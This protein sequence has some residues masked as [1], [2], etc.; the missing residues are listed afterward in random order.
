MRPD[1]RQ[2]GLSNTN[3]KGYNSSVDYVKSML[4]ETDY[5]ISEQY[6]TITV[7]S[8]TNTPRLDQISP[9]A[10][11]YVY[12]VDYLGMTYGG[13]GSVTAG[14]FLGSILSFFPLFLIPLFVSVSHKLCKCGQLS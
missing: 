6:F 8:E 5:V 11:T 3:K 9:F 10:Q 7:P 1:K 12:S 4:A 14:V 2:R 13:S